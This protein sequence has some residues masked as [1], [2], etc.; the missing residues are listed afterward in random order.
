MVTQEVVRWITFIQKLS[1]PWQY[2]PKYPYPVT[3]NE[4]KKGEIEGDWGRREYYY[5]ELDEVWW[6]YPNLN[7]KQPLIKSPREWRVYKTYSWYLLLCHAYQQRVWDKAMKG[8]V[9]LWAMRHTKNIGRFCLKML[10]E[11]ITEP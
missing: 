8:R 6:N 7:P 5:Y 4:G 2:Y 11:L 1:T 10:A 9:V 3:Q